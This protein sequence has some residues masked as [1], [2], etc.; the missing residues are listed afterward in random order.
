[1]KKILLVSAIV[2]H[3]GACAGTESSKWQNRDSL[4]STFDLLERDV[5]SEIPEPKN[6][7]GSH[8]GPRVNI[9]KRDIGSYQM[10]SRP[11]AATSGGYVRTCHTGSRGGTYTITSGGNR[12]YAGC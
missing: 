5:A 3:L 11:G 4:A 8:A 12:N 1:M 9:A 7:A 6:D 2:S 10:H